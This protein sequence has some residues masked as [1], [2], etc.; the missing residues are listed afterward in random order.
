MENKARKKSKC[1]VVVIAARK[2]GVGKTFAAIA[3]AVNAAFGGPDKSRPKLKV[4]FIDVDS[5]QNSTY[6]F[7]KHFGAKQ[8]FNKVLLPKNSD[9][10]EGNIYNITDIFM[11][12]DFIEYPTQYEN[13]HMIPSD[14]QIDNF[15]GREFAGTSQESLT[16][17]SATQFQ[18]LI[19]LVEDDYD[20]IVIDTPPSKTHACQGAIA[21]ATD[22]IVVANLDTWNTENALPG[23]MSDIDYNNNHHRDIDNPINITGIL[24]NKIS[25]SAMTNDEKVQLK[26]IKTLFPKFVHK[27]FYFVD[28]VAFK[29][30]QMPQD[31]ENFDYMK[32]VETATQM[33]NFHEHISNTILKEIY[34]E[35]EGEGAR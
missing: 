19:S 16:Q 23:M 11:G 26:A 6:F 35:L 20:L 30:T 12:N 9:C 21:A 5:Q 32:N 15:K 14:G 7:L 18:K 25:S 24:V 27:G 28:R 34:S 4:L 10:P 1:R 33:R 22:C 31:P 3:L 8:T 29:T 13:I 17:A 2:G